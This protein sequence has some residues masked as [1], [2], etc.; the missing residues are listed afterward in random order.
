MFFYI[1]HIV[2]IH[3]LAVFAAVLTGYK[4]SDMVLSTWVTDSPQLKGYGF[5]LLAV[6]LL[7]IA[8]VIALYPLCKWYDAYKRSHR[9]KQWLSYI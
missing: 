1:L 8:V 5:S 2:F 6:Y 4:A 3:L 9:E 7:W